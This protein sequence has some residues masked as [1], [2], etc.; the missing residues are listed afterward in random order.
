MTSET[1]RV[2]RSQPGKE[3]GYRYPKEREQFSV[4]E[5]YMTMTRKEEVK[6]QDTMLELFAGA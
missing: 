2:N 3:E 5:I 1:C 6:C 4:D